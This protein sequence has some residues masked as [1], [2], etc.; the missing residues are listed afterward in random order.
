MSLSG[1]I[2]A[3][4]DYRL[5]THHTVI[6]NCVLVV[7]VYLLKTKCIPLL[8]NLCELRQHYSQILTTNS[9]KIVK[10]I[11]EKNMTK[12]ITLVLSEFS[13]CPF[14]QHINKRFRLL[15]FNSLDVNS[16]NRVKVRCNG[17]NCTCLLIYFNHHAQMTINNIDNMDSF[18]LVNRLSA[19]MMQRIGRS[20]KTFGRVFSFF[21]TFWI[22]RK[23]KRIVKNYIKACNQDVTSCDG[24]ELRGLKDG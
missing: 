7:N 15:I 23:V 13:A 17:C 16:R 10:K 22:E 19:I 18:S 4:V 20:R 9:I 12:W 14:A 2:L 1:P 3:I 24:I 8:I 6:D 5:H 21:V 11:N